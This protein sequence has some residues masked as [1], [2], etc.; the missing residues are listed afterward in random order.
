MAQL[1]IDIDPE[2]VASWDGEDWDDLVQQVKNLIHQSHLYKEYFQIRVDIGE[3]H[4]N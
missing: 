2:S 3:T 1:I 4:R